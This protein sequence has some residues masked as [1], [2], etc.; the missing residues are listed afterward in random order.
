[1]SSQQEQFESRYAQIATTDRVGWSDEY[2]STIERY[3]D[4]LAKAGVSGGRLLELGCGRGN[5]ALSFASQGWDVTGVDFSPSAIEWAKRL[6]AEVGQAA[7]FEVADLRQEW[8]FADNS[9]DVVIDASCLHFFHG[10]DRGH[11]LNEARRVLKPGGV[12][13]LSTIVNQPEEKDWEFLGYDPVTRTSV[14]HG[15]VMNYYAT[16][17]ELM[18]AL[19]GA[20][21]EVRYSEMTNVDHELIWLVAK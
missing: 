18:G 19:E 11:F 4:L 10:V 17:P 13:L 16:V 7:T 2:E 21:F 20:G 1:M 8:P 5:V 3:R 6:A 14:Q 12:F 9:F 15:V